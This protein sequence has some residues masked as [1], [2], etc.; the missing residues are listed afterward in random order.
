MTPAAMSRILACAIALCMPATL[1]ARQVPA[2]DSVGRNRID[3]AHAERIV[4]VAEDGRETALSG[5]PGFI[6]VTAPCATQWYVPTVRWIVEGRS[7]ST[8][9]MR[10]RTTA[11]MVDGFRQ[12]ASVMHV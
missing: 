3:L 9:E 4:L 6:D 12:C 7:G 11:D 5:P 1:A 10:Y 2:M 8:D